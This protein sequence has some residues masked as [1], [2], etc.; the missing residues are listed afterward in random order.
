MVSQQEKKKKKKLKLAV[1][2]YIHAMKFPH[3]NTAD[4]R[5][6]ISV[7]NKRNERSGTKGKL[8]KKGEKKKLVLEI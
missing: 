1:F 3:D 4:L 2:H 8:S 6:S 7:A 5:N